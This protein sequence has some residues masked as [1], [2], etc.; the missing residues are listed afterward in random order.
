[1]AA[2]LL[3]WD[4]N[5]ATMT[6]FENT[7]TVVPSEIEDNSYAKFWGVNNVHYGLGE[8]VNSLNETQVN[9]LETRQHKSDKR[10]CCLL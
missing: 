8:N 4:T 6:S 9:R 2:V 3:F 1:M 7:I 10:F 5:M